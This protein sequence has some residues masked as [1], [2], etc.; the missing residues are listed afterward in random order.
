MI[1][2]LGTGRSGTSEVAEILKYLGVDMGDH[3]PMPDSNNPR[4]YFEDRVFIGFNRAFPHVN[5]KEWLRNIGKHIADK[6]EPWGLKDPNILDN[7]ELLD[8]YLSLKPDIIVCTRDKKSIIRSF[9]K[10]ARVPKHEAKN[11]YE[12][13]NKLLYKLPSPFLTIDCYQNNKQHAIKEWFYTTNTWE[14]TPHIKK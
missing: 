6:K 1:L 8:F 2:V 12:Q 7:E 14:T 3:F 13:R 11:I 10:T 9:M 5:R 4:G